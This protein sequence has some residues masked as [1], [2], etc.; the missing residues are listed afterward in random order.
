MAD[1]RARPDATEPTPPVSLE[2]HVAANPANRAASSA[3]LTRHTEK[4]FTVAV[5]LALTGLT[6]WGTSAP[7]LFRAP[8]TSTT[9]GPAESGAYVYTASDLDFEIT[10]PGRP[11][12]LRT[13]IPLGD[14]EI[15][16]YTVSWSDPSGIY[17]LAYASHPT[18]DVIDS[19]AEIGPSARTVLEDSVDDMVAAAGGVLQE[20]V[21]STLGGEPSRTGIIVVEGGEIRFTVTIRDGNPIVLTSGGRSAQSLEPFAETLHFID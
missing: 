7:M 4:V 9:G 18:D 16:K 20:S 8:A 6:W 17:A 1:T 2:G 11:D 3:N 12:V 19:G 10:F 13:E 5:A 15:A 21:E 14:G